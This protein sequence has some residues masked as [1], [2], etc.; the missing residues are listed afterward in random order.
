MLAVKPF[1][2]TS[3]WIF[4]EFGLFLRIYRLDDTTKLE[5]NMG[6]TRKHCPAHLV[7]ATVVLWGLLVVEATIDVDGLC[8]LFI[9]SP[10]TYK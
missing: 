6:F 4:S 9:F 2:D 7:V 8:S 5:S 1:L 3:K 10:F